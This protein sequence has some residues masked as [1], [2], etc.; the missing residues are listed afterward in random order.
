MELRTPWDPTSV[1]PPLPPA[2]PSL[3]KRR[4]RRPAT[5][6][7]LAV[8]AA[9]PWLYHHLTISGPADAVTAFAEGARGSGIVPWRVEAARLEED[10]FNRGLRCLNRKLSVR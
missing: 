6:Q 7:V 8:E 2:P 1:V 10:I 4:G 3:S 5:T 9:S